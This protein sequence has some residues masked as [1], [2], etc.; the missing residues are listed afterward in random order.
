M[1]EQGSGAG[2]Q[3]GGANGRSQGRGSGGGALAPGWWGCPAL[4][5][6]QSGLPL[7]PCREQGLG[8][9]VQFLACR[10]ELGLV[11]ISLS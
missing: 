11:S 4:S 8:L 1:G 3:R 2:E 9:A 5:A 6:K 7:Q 10:Q